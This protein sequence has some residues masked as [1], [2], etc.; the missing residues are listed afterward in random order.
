MTRPALV[1]VTEHEEQLPAADL[2]EGYLQHRLAGSS[3]RL[4]RSRIA[5]LERTLRGF[6]DVVGT[7]SVDESAVKRWLT[8]RT[9][10][11]PC[12]VYDEFCT[13][14]ACCTWLSERRFIAAVDWG[15]S[16][17]PRSLKGQGRR[18]AL[19]QAH[20]AEEQFEEHL[21]GVG[22]CE[23]TIGEYVHELAR[24][25]AWLAEKG[26]DLDSAPAS[27]IAA[28][29]ATR[30]NSWST[31]KMVRATFRHAWD[32]TGRERP[33]VGAIRVPPKPRGRYRGLEDDETLVLAEAARSRA[34]DPG[35]AVAL[36]LYAGLRRTEV[37][38]MRWECFDRELDWLTIQGKFGVEATI[39]VHE[40]LQ[41][42]RRTLLA[43]LILALPRST[44][45][46]PKDGCGQRT[47][48]SNV[49][50]AVLPQ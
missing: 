19:R 40:R 15:A 2:V 25:R 5:G 34:D 21:Y 20:L 36:M 42:M 44:R 32:L 22:L 28:Y 38:E 35:L 9:H 24:A 41:V 13:I 18:A 39:P 1:L 7:T 11:A 50:H 16:A 10:L 4:S 43:M 14:R 23:R 48:R 26:H 47:V 27:V 49:G 8:S 3:P 46:P 37:A 30:P 31:R 6:A 45:V 12:T 29:G 17:Y 33:P